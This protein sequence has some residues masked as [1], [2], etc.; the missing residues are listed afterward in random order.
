MTNG[1]KIRAMSDEELVDK[2]YAHYSDVELLPSKFCAETSSEDCN[3]ECEI[4][5]LNWLKKEIN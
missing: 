5:L 4:C 2:L 1:D 3:S